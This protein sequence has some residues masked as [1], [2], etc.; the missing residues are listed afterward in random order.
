MPE[1]VAVI[2][3]VTLGYNAT[4]ASVRITDVDS[5]RDV[6]LRPLSL[7]LS[8]ERED[9]QSPCRGHLRFLPGGVQHAIQG[10][11]GLFDALAGYVGESASPT[12]QGIPKDKDAHQD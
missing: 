11:A 5:E 8:L 9:R 4:P 3:R 7:L 6:P 1:R 10:D 12:E 2:L